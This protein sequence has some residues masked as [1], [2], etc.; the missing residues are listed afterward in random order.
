MSDQKPV[1]NRNA[2]QKISDLENAVMALY[3]TVDNMA[4]DIMT[5]KE[6][7]KLLGNKTDSIVKA[8]SSGEQITDAVISRI[9]VE[10]NVEELSNKVKN[11][12]AQGVLA[13]Q[14]QVEQ[15]S[16]IIGQEVDDQG[17]VKNPRLQFALYAVQQELRDKF[18]GAKVGDTLNLQDGKLK[19]CLLEIYQIQQPKAPEA[20]VAEAPAAAAPEVTPVEAPAAETP[21][22]IPAEDST[23]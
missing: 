20:S 9:M 19:F 1:D 6:A 8:S 22:E 15:N 3:Q 13:P 5:L 23:K 17:E 12:V 2:S 14:D 7:M 21:A 11:M 10:N 18:V 16:F 4:R